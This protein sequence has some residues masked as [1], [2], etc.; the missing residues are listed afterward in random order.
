MASEPVTR[1]TIQCPESIT[2]LEHLCKGIFSDDRT[3][4]DATRKATRPHVGC[5]YIN[6]SYPSR[7]RP[8]ELL[9]SFRS[10]KALHSRQPSGPL[11]NA[12]RAIQHSQSALRRL[13]PFR[14]TAK[15]HDVHLHPWT[16]IIAELLL[17]STSVSYRKKSLHHSRHV[18]CGSIEL[19]RRPSVNHPHRRRCN[20]RAGCLEHTKGRGRWPLNGRTGG[21]R[22]RCAVSRSSARHCG[23]WADPSI[24]GVSV[25]DGE[26]CDNCP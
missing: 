23:Y 1:Y 12:F 11:E 17:P 4:T 21:F 19:H 14:D 15:W 6:Y 20:R 24:R 5:E 18:W 22:A 3:R 2:P 9:H 25:S 16:G 7:L 10:L 26:A 8:S 13:S